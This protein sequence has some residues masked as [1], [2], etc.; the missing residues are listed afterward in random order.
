MTE[1][2]IVRYQIVTGG[3][4]IERETEVEAEEK[5]SVI[6]H[7]PANDL[8]KIEGDIKAVYVHRSNLVSITI[9]KASDIE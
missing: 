9:D 2:A 3:M 5:I 7:G 6:E 8:I 4:N 1:K